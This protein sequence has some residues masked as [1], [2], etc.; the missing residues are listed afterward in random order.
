VSDSTKR[1][2]SNTARFKKLKKPFSFFISS[3]FFYFKTNAM[4]ITSSKSLFKISLAEWSFHKAL[5]ANEISNLDFPAIAKKKFGIEVV[6]Y[7]NLFFKDKAEDAKYLNELLQRCNDNDVQNHLIMVDDEGPLADAD[8]NKRS[9]AV[10]NHYKWVDAAKTLGCAAIRVNAF[11]DGGSAEDVQSAAVDGVS[12]IAEYAGKVGINVLLENHGGYTSDGKWMVAL[13][14]R[15][16]KPN[17]GT[18]PDFGNFCIKREGGHVWNGKCIEKYDR[19]KGVE[20]LMP[21]AKGVS[22][23]AQSFDENGNCIE[24]DYFKMFNIIKES[25]FRGY[26]GIEF[27]NEETNEDE[28]VRKTKALLEK[29]FSSLN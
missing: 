9:Q 7:V 11:S 8:D 6:E 2:S 18:L 28:G 26:V 25:G 22:A 24:T 19:Y 17:V 15:I 10:E 27:S 5:F 3:L 29:V 16:S 14:K 20:E 13:M 1:N 4:Q 21:Y 12:R 23:K